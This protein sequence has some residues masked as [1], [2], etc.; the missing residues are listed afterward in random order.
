MDEAPPLHRDPVLCPAP[1]AL[2]LAAF[3]R[4]SCGHEVQRSERWVCVHV[5]D[6]WRVGRG[7]RWPRRPGVT[8]GRAVGVAGQGRGADL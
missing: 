4:V 6:T 5:C 3:A 8:V 2:R 1:L 7:R